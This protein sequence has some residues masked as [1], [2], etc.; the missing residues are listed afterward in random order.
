M[1]ALL[2]WAESFH[3]PHDISVEQGGTGPPW[4]TICSV[5]WPCAQSVALRSSDAICWQ[6]RNP[7]DEAS[8]QWEVMCSRS[9]ILA[10][11]YPCCLP[12]AVEG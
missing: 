7:L 3:R 1:S 2:R 11:P 4:C 9:L 10:P 6:R 8:A 5:E 12:R